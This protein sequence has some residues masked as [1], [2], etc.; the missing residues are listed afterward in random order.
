VRKGTHVELNFGV[1]HR[2]KDLWGENADDF[3]PERWDSINATSNQPYM[4]FFNGPRTCPAKQ[5]L[6]VQYVYLLVRFVQEFE[7][8]DNRDD[9]LEFVEEHRF[10]KMSRNGVKVAFFQSRE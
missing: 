3:R 5:M 6:L 10:T 9:V 1:M 4:P 7:S 8:M 2:D